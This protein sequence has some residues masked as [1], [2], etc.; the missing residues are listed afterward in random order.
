MKRDAPLVFSCYF[1]VCGNSPVCKDDML[2]FY[3]HPCLQRNVVN[4]EFRDV[5]HLSDF[6]NCNLKL[7]NYQIAQNAPAMWFT[8]SSV[9][10]NYF[11]LNSNSHHQIVLSQTLLTL[12]YHFDSTLFFHTHEVFPCL[13]WKWQRHLVWLNKYQVM[14]HSIVM[15]N[16]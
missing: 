4:A 6:R 14:V 9:N 5:K 2:P 15:L 3:Y 16:Y 7:S 8:S 11:K 1:I 12:F 10:T 13:F